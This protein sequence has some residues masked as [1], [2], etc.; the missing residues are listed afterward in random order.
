MYSFGRTVN[1]VVIPELSEQV[2]LKTLAEAEKKFEEEKEAERKT[3]L[4]FYYNEN[5]DSHLDRAREKA[6]DSGWQAH[7]ATAAQPCRPD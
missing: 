4:D 6:P 7:P 1:Q 3:A 5:M 2:I